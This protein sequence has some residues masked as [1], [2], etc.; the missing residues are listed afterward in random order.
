MPSANRVFEPGKSPDF[1]GSFRNGSIVV[2][3]ASG[4]E[5]DGAGRSTRGEKHG[6]RRHPRESEG[7]GS[8]DEVALRP[9]PFGDTPFR[10]KR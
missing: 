1:F 10:T 6:L 7:P 5:T 3:N 9:F 8:S 2:V 4:T